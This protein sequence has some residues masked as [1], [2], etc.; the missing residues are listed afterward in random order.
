MNKTLITFFTVLFCLTSSVSWSTEYKDLAERDG[1]FYK[2]FSDIPFTGKI[3]GKKTGSFKNGKKDGSWI[4]YHKNGQLYYKGNY[5]LGLAEGSIVAYHNNGKLWYKGNYK[6]GLLNGQWV[7]YFYNGKLSMKYILHLEI[8]KKSM[9]LKEW[10]RETLNFFIVSIIILK[11]IQ[12][13]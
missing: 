10:I 6:N 8:L 5:K 7:T 1:I 12:E 11:N 2:K 4:E 9:K 13:C 3:S